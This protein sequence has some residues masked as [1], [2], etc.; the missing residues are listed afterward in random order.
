[1]RLAD[2]LAMLKPDFLLPAFKGRRLAIA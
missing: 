2:G 1:M